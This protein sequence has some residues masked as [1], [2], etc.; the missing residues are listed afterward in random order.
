M[1]HPVTQILSWCALVTTMQFLPPVQL[2]SASALVL[3]LAFAFSRHKFVQLL[4]RTRWI[5]FSLWLIYAFTTP[6]E[7]LF[8]VP[9]SP[10]REGLL[11]G[12]LQMMRLL[13]ALAALAILLERLQR[14]QLMAGLHSLFLPLQWCGLSRE[15]LAVRL[16]LTLHY[17]EVAMLRSASWQETLNSLSENGES[18]AESKP[19]ELPV[20]PFLWLDG[21][22]LL[23]GGALLGW[24]LI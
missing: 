3:L 14:A 8:D 19:I 24:V 21:L 5:M 20:Y 10:S 13:A 23:A 18:Q 7:A 16:A 2:L 1:L 4:R 9:L 6:G 12:G 15:R 17:A 11:D 22:V